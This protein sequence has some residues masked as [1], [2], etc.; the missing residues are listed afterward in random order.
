MESSFR[1]YEAAGST[2]LAKF[3]CVFIFVQPQ[4]TAK[5][6]KRFLPF[7]EPQSQAGFIFSF[8][9]GFELWAH[10]IPSP[11]QATVGQ[12]SGL[13]PVWDHWLSGCN[14]HQALCSFGCRGGF[15]TDL[16]G[17]PLLALGTQKHP[18]Q[19]GKCPQGRWWSGQG[20]RRWP[21]WMKGSR[22]KKMRRGEKGGGGGKGALTDRR[23]SNKPSGLEQ[24]SGGRPLGSAS[25]L[26][27]FLSQWP[28]RMG[29]TSPRVDILY[30]SI[31]L[32]W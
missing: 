4:I 20:R 14:S 22:A 24:G 8:N 25:C 27:H 3:G 18:F 16:P 17:G 9:S 28:C 23:A 10:S 31:W 1:V 21:P 11:L 19:G 6:W 26:H 13:L 12:I 32:P 30:L 29:F 15:Q 5:N 7:L 2:Q